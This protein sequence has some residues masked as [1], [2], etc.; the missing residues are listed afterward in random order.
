MYPWLR[1]NFNLDSQKWAVYGIL[2]TCPQA[3]K[4]AFLGCGTKCQSKQLGSDMLDEKWVPS[5]WSDLEE[6]N[7]HSF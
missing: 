7:G 6:S 1:N 3:R 2:T 5:V 4:S